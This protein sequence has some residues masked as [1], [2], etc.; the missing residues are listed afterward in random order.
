MIGITLQIWNQ[1]DCGKMYMIPYQ[2][3]VETK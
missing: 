2:K 3:N 1:G